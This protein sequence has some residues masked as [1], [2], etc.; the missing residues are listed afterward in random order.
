[1]VIGLFLKLWRLQYIFKP[2]H[3]SMADLWLAAND[4]LGKDKNGFVHAK[5]HSTAVKKTWCGCP[6]PALI[7]QVNLINNKAKFYSF[8]LSFFFDF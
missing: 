2:D 8:L 3:D 1:M 6:P 4:G 5:G 7:Q